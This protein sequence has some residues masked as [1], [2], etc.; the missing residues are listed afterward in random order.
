MQPPVPQ[1]QE[2][3]PLLM[4]EPELPQP[5]LL[6]QLLQP[7][8]LQ[9]QRLPQPQPQPEPELTPP[10]AWFSQ[11]GLQQELLTKS[12]KMM[13]LTLE[14]Q[15]LQA[16]ISPPKKYRGGFASTTFY[17]PGVKLGTA[18]VQTAPRH[19]GPVCGPPSGH[20]AG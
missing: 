5:Q 20:R 1:E 14:E 4:L 2:Q 18:T 7:Q 13:P 3:L 12:G 6:P 15:E 17:A 11:Q 19:T 16:I 8:L 10:T 9:P